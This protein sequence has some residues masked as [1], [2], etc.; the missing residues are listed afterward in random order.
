MATYNNM[1]AIVI[2]ALVAGFIGY[3]LGRK[4]TREEEREKIVKTFM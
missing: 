4:A 2:V 3:T 1:L